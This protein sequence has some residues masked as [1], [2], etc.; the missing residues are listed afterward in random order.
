MNNK[1]PEEH[2][3]KK[4]TNIFTAAGHLVV[5]HQVSDGGPTEPDRQQWGG[6]EQ[7]LERQESRIRHVTQCVHCTRLFRHVSHSSQT[8]CFLLR[9]PTRPT[10]MGTTEKSWLVSLEAKAGE[11]SVVQG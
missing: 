4:Q 10:A 5:S 9:L 7:Q 11:T 8:E 1:T 2:G 6:R 3:G